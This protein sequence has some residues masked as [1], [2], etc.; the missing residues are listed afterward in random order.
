MRYPAPIAEQLGNVCPKCGSETKSGTQVSRLQT[1]PSGANADSTQTHR[2][3]THAPIHILLDNLRSVF[4]VGSIFRTADGM[5]AAHIYLCGITPTPEHPRLAKTALGAER[6]VPW[7]HYN[8]G[9]EAVHKLQE[10][11]VKLLGLEAT[12]SADSLF[13]WQ[14]PSVTSPIALVVGNEITG[15]DPKILGACDHQL[16]LPMLGEKGSLNVAVACGI[17]LYQLHFGVV[18]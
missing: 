16:S 2:R 1:P 10:E 4:N 8:N 15:I 13:N 5:G 7:T 18:E 9:L 6:A 14:N 11:R 3:A 12:P 17:A